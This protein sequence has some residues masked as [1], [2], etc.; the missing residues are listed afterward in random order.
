MCLLKQWRLCKTKLHN[1]VALGLAEK[2]AGCIA[3]SRKKYWRLATNSPQIN[4]ALGFAYWREQGLVILVERYY[5][6]RM[7]S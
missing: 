4:K 5:E 6:L 2:W 3:F 7:S 1:L